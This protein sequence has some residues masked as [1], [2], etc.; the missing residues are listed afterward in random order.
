M[1]TYA[2]CGEITFPA[3]NGRQEFRIRRFSEC[4]IES[5][6]KGLTDTAEIILPRKVKDFDRMKIG[7]W[8]RPGDPVRIDLGYDNNIYTEFTGYV[9]A[10]PAGVPLVLE[11]ENEMYNLKRS[12]IS[13]SKT[14][15]TLKEL[16]QAIVPGYKIVCNETKIIGS[17]RFKDLT[18]AQCLEELKK[19]GIICFF[20]DKVLYA[21]DN[22]SHLEGKTHSII[23]EHT[24][25]ESI[26][27]KEIHQT[28]VFIELI[29]KIGKRVKVEHGDENPGLII[30]RTFSGVN[31]SES[32]VKD[33]AKALY[34]LAKT[35]GLDGDVILFGIPRVKLG[36]S[37]KITSSI[38]DKAPEYGKPYRVVAITKTFSQNGYRQS[39][40][41]GDIT[42]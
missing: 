21:L 3:H 13:I 29:R 17:I 19:Q 8:F 24:A 16:L 27:V 41:L 32:E 12:T 42:I 14:N 6:L 25:G 18:Q 34:N 31:M 23:L 4:K 30:R 22:L 39:C 9:K 11:C 26:K 35:P 33:M 7:E 38:Y 28:K 10:T 2:L 37:L 36:D 5:S 20:K 1:S 15:S 40:K